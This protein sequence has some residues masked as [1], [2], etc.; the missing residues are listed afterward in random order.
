MKLAAALVTYAWFFFGL[1]W[2]ATLLY[3]VFS[4]GETDRES[5]SSGE[6]MLVVFS[7][8]TLLTWGRSSWLVESSAP[9]AGEARSLTKPTAKSTS[10]VH[11]EHRA[12]PA[13]LSGI[14][15]ERICSAQ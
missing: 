9:G 2:V 11:R 8:L 12:V 6:R 13:K 7:I 5:M 10:K 3:A 4:R 14:M 15:S 1:L